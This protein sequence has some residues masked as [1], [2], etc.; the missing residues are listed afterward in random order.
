[1]AILKSQGVVD[2]G[3]LYMAHERSSVPGSI[4]CRNLQKIH[5][6]VELQ[7]ITERTIVMNCDR[8][9]IDSQVDFCRIAD[10]SC[11]RERICFCNQRIR[12]TKNGQERR[13]RIFSYVQVFTCPISSGIGCNKYYRIHSFNQIHLPCKRII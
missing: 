2:G 3:V 9:I 12:R 5:S 4:Y 10:S 13:L 11:D 8:I 7:R 6:F 1:M